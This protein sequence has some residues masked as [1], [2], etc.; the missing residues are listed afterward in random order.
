MLSYLKVYGSVQWT[1]VLKLDSSY[2]LE[3]EDY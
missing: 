3:I 1:A 2:H